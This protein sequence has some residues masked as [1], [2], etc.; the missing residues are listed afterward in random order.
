MI[1]GLSGEQ[2]QAMEQFGAMM[3]E[4]MCPVFGAI[5]AGYRDQGFTRDESMSLVRMHLDAWLR[6]M[7]PERKDKG[8]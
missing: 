2:I 1:K 6:G 5:F 3:R 8:G 7:P 4:H